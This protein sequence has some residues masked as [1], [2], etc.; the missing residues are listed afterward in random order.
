MKE[1]LLVYGH[2]GLKHADGEGQSGIHRHDP[3]QLISQCDLLRREL[4]AEDH[5]PVACQQEADAQHQ[6]AQRN[7]GEQEHAVEL[8][9]VLFVVFGFGAGVV[10]DVG[11]AKAEGQHIQ[12]GDDGQDG[13]INAELAVAQP[14]DHNGRVHQRDHRA[15]PHGQIG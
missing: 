3:Q 15:Q 7:V 2:V 10:A 14:L 6:S 12:I 13:L 5:V 9:H 8:G 4:F 1:V 11:A